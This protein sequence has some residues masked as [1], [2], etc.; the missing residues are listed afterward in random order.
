MTGIAVDDGRQMGDSLG[1]QDGH[2]VMQTRRDSW[3]PCLYGF[4]V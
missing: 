3:I 4:Q 2:Q 1:Q